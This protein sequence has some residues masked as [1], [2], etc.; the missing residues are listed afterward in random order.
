MYDS[1]VLAMVAEQLGLGHPI[2]QPL[3]TL[4]GWV[5]TRLPLDSLLLL[6]AFSAIVGAATMIPAV[7]LCEAVLPANREFS[8]RTTSTI[9]WT[10]GVV[11]LHPLLWE[12]STRIEAYPL[13]IFLGLWASARLG[14]ALIAGDRRLRPYLT[15][16]LA[17]GLAASA[18]AY[19]AVG[20]ALAATPWL[21]GSLL[22]R[23]TQL[24][25]LGAMIAG[26]VVGLLPYAYVPLVALR[27]D[28]VVWGRPVG[29][30]SLV[31]YFTGADYQRSR[32]I[33]WGDFFANLRDLIAW[34]NDQGVLALLLFGLLGYILCGRRSPLAF[35]VVCGA[36]LM[37]LVASNAIFAADVLDHRGYLAEAGWL[38]A[39]G[40]GILIAATYERGRV[41]RAVSAIAVLGLV[42]LA[43]PQ[44]WRRSR[45]L[46][47]VTWVIASHALNAAPPNAILLVA[48][49]HWAGPIW[50]LQESRKVRPDVVVIAHG[51][52][53]SRWY[54]EMLFARHPGLVRV[55]LEAPDRETRL[56]RF[57]TANA[58]RPLRVEDVEL[59]RRLGLGACFG[60]W[61]LGV[62]PSCET[63][64]VEPGLVRYV[65]E[66]R[67][68]LGGGSPGTESLLAA[69]AFRRGHDL[70]AMGYVRPSVEALLSAT[71]HFEEL[72]LAQLPTRGDQAFLHPPEYE[73]NLA[74][75]HSSR[76]LDFAARIAALHGA[77]GLAIELRELTREGAGR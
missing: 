43:P 76:N 60:N 64:G 40:I 67:E 12:P 54:W 7:S 19:C 24:R 21:L 16:G 65:S 51:L 77:H 14:H 11:G 27:E 47:D 3:H 31:R 9:P 2:G 37:S 57:L 48:S 74:L 10:I 75:G 59:A 29:L 63:I 71:E 8:D 55:P 22:A 30:Q 13:A 23:Q 45:H 6:N 72:S 52:S 1:P 62:P 44:P 15:S 4:L 66:A 25:S 41:V 46:D 32:E 53:S 58:D 38:G 56:R 69:L 36:L 17:L 49:D 70:P 34:S 5:L 35:Y 18:N 42:L 68:R 39:S 33:T 28:A 73:T 50:Y 61:L 20:I 26:G